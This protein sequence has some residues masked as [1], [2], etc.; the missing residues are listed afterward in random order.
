MRYYRIYRDGIIID[1]PISST[2]TSYHDTGV[3][4]S[5]Q[6]CY[7]IDAVDI[8][9][10]VSPR[11]NKKCATTP[12][13]PLDYYSDGFDF[14][15][16]IPD[17]TGWNHGQNYLDTCTID[18]SDDGYDFLEP[19]DYKKS[20]PGCETYHPG[21]DWNKDGGEAP[22]ELVYAIS[23]GVV[24]VALRDEK[25]KN[26]N[27]GF[28]KVVLIEHEAPPGY[29]FRL[30]HENG[31][32]DETRNKVYSLYAHL[33]SVDESLE[34]G[35]IV[36]RGKTKIGTFG[37]TGI[38]T[39]RHLHLEIRSGIYEISDQKTLDP[40]TNTN[41]SADPSNWGQSTWDLFAISWGGK[42]FNL[43]SVKTY[44]VDPTNFIIANRTLGPP[45]AKGFVKTF[46]GSLWDGG[47]SI[48]Q[49]S[50][51]GYIVAGFTYSLGA[52]YVLVLK[53]DLNGNIQWQKTFGS[54]WAAS[55]QQT[56]DG[57]YIV[58]GTGPGPLD[59][60]LVLKLDS[61]GNVQWAKTFG[62][63][64]FDHATSVQQTSDGGY[65][66]AGFTTSFGAA[67][68]YDALV[69]KL[70]PNGDTEWAKM[71][72]GGDADSGYSIQQTSDGGYILAGTTHGAG[73]S[74]ALIVKLKSN[75]EIDWQKTFR[76]GLAYSIQQTSDGGY[77]VAGVWDA[78]VLKLDSS[79]NKQWAKTF[80]GSKEDFAFSI[81]QTSDGG[82]IVVGGT[83][84]FGAGYYSDILV[85]KLTSMGNISKCTPLKDVSLTEEIPALTT[86]D[87]SITVIDLGQ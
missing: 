55:I 80:S 8:A 65:I 38:T 20:E 4:P 72:G 63:W 77:I 6:Y 9:G 19:A 61:S 81:Q 11:S 17:G 75:G 29:T 74:D 34:V 50:D 64:G 7:E 87:V 60:V 49:T 2:I 16:G 56:T 54:G 45:F 71:L 5:K 24:R 21:E 58:A 15:V 25:Y 36:K 33:D 42:A 84:S 1:Y 27:N 46:G 48:Q 18:H 23:N 57:G 47:R 85:L 10:N 35:Q 22:D 31:P 32:I 13:L 39:G 44:W 66:V 59:D 52:T 41:C 37:D 76:L 70:K 14:G 68:Y 62:G 82:Y 28:G 3:N 30:A 43:A 40:T 53:L 67:G 69:L 51:G 86:K 26:W 78:L 79:G 73:Y 12:D 83:T